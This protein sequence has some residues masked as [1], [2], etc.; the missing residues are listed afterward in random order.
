MY[1]KKAIGRTGVYGL[2]A[3]L[4]AALAAKVIPPYHR[5][6]IA[7]A[8]AKERPL[9]LPGVATGRISSKSKTDTGPSATTATYGNWLLRCN[10]R[11]SARICEVVQTIYVQGQ[12]TPFAR[13]AIG[14][15]KKSD[16]LRLVVQVPVNVFLSSPLQ[17]IFKKNAPSIKLNFERCIPAGCFAAMQSAEE[18]VRRL[19]AQSNPVRISYKNGS[20]REVGFQISLRGFDAALDALAKS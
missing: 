1:L 19:R 4:G 16:P 7:T 17:I 8:Y 10:V 15:E 5:S 14:R 20:Q 18:V 3:V 12:K 9:V 2:A 6:I 11:T 13:I